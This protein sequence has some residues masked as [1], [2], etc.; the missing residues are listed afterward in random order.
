MQ[1]PWAALDLVEDDQIGVAVMEF[2]GT[3]TFLVGHALGDFELAGPIH[4]EA[5]TATR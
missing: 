4:Q 3:G 2:G 1:S 5:R